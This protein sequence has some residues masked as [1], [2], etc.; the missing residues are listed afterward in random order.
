M[1][2]RQTT[3]MVL[4]INKM[5]AIIRSWT[6]RKEKRSTTPRYSPRGMKSVRRTGAVCRGIPRMCDAPISQTD[7]MTNPPSVAER[8]RSQA[9]GNAAN[10]DRVTLEKEN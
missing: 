5:T 9:D 8:T 10:G 4:T 7:N 2:Q 3:A 6:A 1:R